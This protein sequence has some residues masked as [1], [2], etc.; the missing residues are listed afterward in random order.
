MIGAAVYWIVA[1]YLSRADKLKEF[2]YTH[3]LVGGLLFT[4]AL[5]LLFDGDTLFFAIATEATVLHLIHYR[6][7]N[8]GAAV[9]GHAL[10]AVL[11]MLLFQRIGDQLHDE[12]ALV[13]ARAL[14]D[15]WTIAAMVGLSYIFRSIVFRRIYFLFGVFALAGWFSRELSDNILFV[16]LTIQAFAIHLETRRINDSIL[17]G[18]A[19]V[20]SALL[21]FWLI[22]R[23]AGRQV[24]AAVVVSTYALGNLLAIVMAAVVAWFSESQKARTSY[25]LIAHIAFMGWLLSELST[26]HEGQGYVTIAWGIYGVILLILGLRRATPGL[27]TVALVTLLVVV[28]KLFL[29]DLAHLQAIFRI[30][31]FMG[32]GAAFLALSYYF[33]ALWKSDA[34][35][36]K[37]SD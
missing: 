30:F 13:G 35:K 29:V 24:G 25:S 21:G 4:I 27:Q 36:N 17:T 26:L 3:T 32:F 33:K 18:G 6:T 19:H 10:F 1:Y 28:G 12:R 11:A 22:R 2:G 7:R 15:I 37:K 5:C 34:L 16:V 23:L 14:A 31:L 20:F 8:L 9:S